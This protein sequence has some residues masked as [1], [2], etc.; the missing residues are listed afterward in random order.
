MNEKRMKLLINILV[1]LSLLASGPAWA[2]TEE[3]VAEAEAVEATI[4]ASEEQE[5]EQEQEQVRYWV[6]GSQTAVWPVPLPRH[7]VS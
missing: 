5:Q 7:S 2:Q 4:E 1:L 6:A 3:S